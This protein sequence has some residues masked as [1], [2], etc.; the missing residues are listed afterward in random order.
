M[1]IVN[2]DEVFH[3]KTRSDPIIINKFKEHHI[4][5]RETFKQMLYTSYA[6]K[7]ALDNTPACECGKT[8]KRRNIGMRCPACN[9]EVQSRS[10]QTLESIVWLKAPD[11]V[12][13]LINPMIWTLLSDKFKK[14]NFNIIQWLCDTTYQPP[15][16]PPKIMPQLLALNIP[17]GYNNFVRNFFATVDSQGNA[18]GP[19]IIERLL[20]IK[21]F[22]V[23]KRAVK[24][25][26]E[27]LQPIQELLL[28]N[29]DACFS[30]YL[31]IPNRAVFVIENTDMSTYVDA[32]APSAV[33]AIVALIGLDDPLFNYSTRTKE[34]R[35]VKFFAQISA[36]YEDFNRNTFSGKPGVARKHLVAT[37]SNWSF[38]SVISS[39]TEDHKYNEIHI[40]WGIGV[41]VFRTLLANKLKRLKYSPNE[42]FRLMAQYARRRHPLLEQLFA[43]LIAESP[44]IGIPTLFQRNPSLE[45][46]SMQRKFI[47]K[48]KTDPADPTISVSILAIR[49]YNA[50]FDGDEMNG[51]LLLDNELTDAFERL[52]PAC[53]ALDQTTPYKISA[54]LSKSKP[55]TSTTASYF[56]WSRTQPPDPV[57]LARMALIPVPA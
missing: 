4:D 16:K 12:E 49:G 32:I 23:K 50:D 21:D 22:R 46:G 14:G 51:M 43:E 42:M 18:I 24:G 39:L 38:R 34:N 33:D 26:M 27:P 3:K 36:Y 30:D 17:R 53:S 31:S 52:A 35:L 11:K 28:R 2:Q 15:L 45:R 13:K 10:S 40:P 7:D 44:Y 48:V 25:A 19:G 57:K 20:T 6:P 29:R 9:T 47:T 8:T 1:E 56:E 37:R 5:A 41:G 54:N 55:W